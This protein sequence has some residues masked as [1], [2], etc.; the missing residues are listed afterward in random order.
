MSDSHQPSVHTHY[1]NLKVARNAPPEVVRA[2][3]RALAQR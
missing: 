2:A 1:D 3:F